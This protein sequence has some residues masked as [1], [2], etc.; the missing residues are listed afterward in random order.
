MPITGTSVD[1]RQARYST[2]K[3]VARK[4]DFEIVK[5]NQGSIKVCSY[6]EERISEERSRNTTHSTHL[7]SLRWES[8]IEVACLSESLQPD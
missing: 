1:T 6:K 7:T 4:R 5:K 8:R 2:P 3:L